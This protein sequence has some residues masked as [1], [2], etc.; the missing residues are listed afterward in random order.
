MKMRFPSTWDEAMLKILLAAV[1]LLFFHAGA[2]HAGD[3]DPWRLL[4]PLQKGE[5][6]HEDWS[7]EELSAGDEHLTIIIR[8]GSGALA[9]K[10]EVRLLQR[11]DEKP[12]FA[13]THSFNILYMTARSAGAKTD[14][15][16][17]A[18][19]LK[20]ADIIRTNDRGDWKGPLGYSVWTGTLGVVLLLAFFLLAAAGFFPPLRQ[21]LLA[22]GRHVGTLVQ[23][24]E[25]ILLCAVVVLAFVVRAPALQAPFEADMDAQRIFIAGQPLSQILL[26]QYED[27]RHPHLYY[28]LLHFVQYL[29]ISER[30]MRMP[31]L[32]FSLLALVLAFV[33]V[34]ARFST[35]AA[36][37]VALLL[38]VCPPFVHHARQVSDTMLFSVMALAVVAAWERVGRSPD[39][40]GFILLA[41]ANILMLSAYYM[42]ILVL[43]AEVVAALLDAKRRERL[44]S[45]GLALAAVLA[46]SGFT[47]LRLGRTF[48]EDLGLRQTAD[49]FPA[50]L[51]GSR[52]GET[53]AGELLEMVLP[54]AATWAA[55]LI[56]AGCLALALFVA[57]K[58][59]FIRLWLLV[60][61]LPPLALVLLATRVRLMPYYAVFTIPLVFMLAASGLQ[62]LFEEESFPWAAKR[63]FASYLKKLSVLFCGAWLLYAYSAGLLSDAGRIYGGSRIQASAADM[64][65]VIRAG[66]LPRCI[67]CDFLPLSHLVMYYASTDPMALKR[68][69]VNREMPA[70][71]CSL[72]KEEV[73]ALTDNA[74]LGPSW[75]EEAASALAS[76]AGHDFW[77]L[78]NELT[79]NEKLLEVAQGRCTREASRGPLILYA[80]TGPQP[81]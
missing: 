38:A 37:L 81:P 21:R 64:A 47:L 20:L 35:G 61:V 16:L 72:G 43:L 55:A 75:R 3:R 41:A 57:L 1:F 58:R 79:P 53:M 62:I 69:C 19:L 49:M 28:M 15:D 8:K 66:N 73:I 29:S 51:W 68:A 39:R 80:C 44:R 7:V 36:L 65:G 32:V 34:R 78:Y 63:P 40:A 23:K 70:R 45:Y 59:P 52:S 31:S 22:A 60:L 50:H 17:A 42:G 71:T 2:L 54:S 67:V 12:A 25:T 5:R 74:R 10:V 18:A 4:D 46:G 77:F 6:F 24:R 33:M 14:E 76:M 26:Y 13:K 27:A 56:L 11:D 48:L 9:Q 30:V